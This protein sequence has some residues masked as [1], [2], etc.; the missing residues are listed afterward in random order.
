MKTYTKDSGDSEK[1]DTSPKVFQRSKLK[2]N[3]SIKHFTFTQKQKQLIDII[4]DKH[5][6]MI[7]IDGPA[8]TTKTYVS[9][10]CALQLLDQKRCSD[11]IYVRSIIESASK[12]LG[13]LPG[14]FCD[15]F[16][17]FLLPLED[18]L[19]ELLPKGDIDLLFKE[20]R[21]QPI[22]INFLRGASYNAKVIWSEE[23]Q[24]F[25]F[26]E[27]TTLITRLGEFSKLICVG[28][29]RQSDL[30]GKSGFKAMFDLFT[31]TDSAKEGIHTFEFTKDD[32]L[33]S[34]TLKFI[35]EK[36]ESCDYDRG[37]TH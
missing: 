26:K 35:L 9:A 13:T 29:R 21:I 3:L 33:R 28:D 23:S 18:K 22:P 32:V 24:N 16:K 30:N 27:L 37:N 31:G 20:Q 25:S 2:G 34:G 6:K 14:E 10:Y 36:L 11:I 4:L 12:S 15:K 17:P 1:Q 7:F 5:T 19:S 8:G